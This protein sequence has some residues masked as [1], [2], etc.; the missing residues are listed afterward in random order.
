MEELRM[1]HPIFTAFA[2][3][4]ITIT[5][6]VTPASATVF[7]NVV[8]LENQHNISNIGTIYGNGYPGG[9]TGKTGIY[10]WTNAGHAPDVVLQ[11]PS[12][13]F[14]IEMPQS[15]VNSWMSI[16]SLDQGPRNGP[17]MGSTK[18]NYIRELWGRDFDPT[19]KT[20]ADAQMAEAFSAAIF[21]IIYET[22]SSWNVTSGTGFYCTGLEQAATDTAN[23]WLSQ[24][25][26]NTAYFANNL[27]A[28]TRYDGQDY[29]V[30][31]PE[32]ATLSLLAIGAAALLRRR[33]S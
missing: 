1:R 13:G 16:M 26:G 4:V 27:Y 19:W 3:F 10:S 30:Q 25:N 29:V 32:P 23:L 33:K 11:I 6:I 15:V 18:A 21:E 20:G 9:L 5:F 14:C 8:D 28:V 22:D 7:S 2:L 12:W 24:L 17:V 31:T